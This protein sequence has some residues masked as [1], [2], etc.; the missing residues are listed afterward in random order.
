MALESSK[1]KGVASSSRGKHVTH[2]TRE[3]VCLVFSLMTGRLINVR[4]IIKDVL[5]CGN[6]KGPEDLHSPLLSICECNLY[7]DNVLSHLYGM[8]MLQLRMSEDRVDSNLESDAND[9][10][11]S[12]MGEVA[13]APMDDED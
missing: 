8:K 1:G 4:V 11:D 6:D 7:I 2:V 5:I 12:K 9:G 13:Y 3:R 10:E